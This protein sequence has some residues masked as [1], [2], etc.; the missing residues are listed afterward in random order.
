MAVIRKGEVAE[1]IEFDFGTTVP[2]VAPAEPPAFEDL[3]PRAAPE[4]PP[5]PE[6]PIAPAEPPP[7]PVVEVP[8]ALVGSLYEEAVLRG[9]DDGKAQVLAELSVLQE[10]YAAALDQLDAVSRQLVD[11]NRVRLIDLSCQVAERLLRHHLSLHP[12]HLLDAIHE[13]LSDIKDREEVVVHCSADDHAFLTGRRAELSSGLGEVFQ[14][15]V[16]VDDALELGDFR[17]ETRTTSAD[18][19]I[20]ARLE[21]A[22]AAMLAGDEEESGA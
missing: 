2:A 7:P 6:A 20:R 17:V 13:V 8:E 3:T 9:I 12:Q 21:E 22:R 5:E 18:G 4:P 15:Q 16:M 10:R 1:V 11:R 14:V 19:A